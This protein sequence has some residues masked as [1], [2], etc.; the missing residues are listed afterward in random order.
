MAMTA[1]RNSDRTPGFP[2][3]LFGGD[4]KDSQ[5][6]PF[7][8]TRRMHSR[9]GCRPNGLQRNEDDASVD[10]ERSG[11]PASRCACVRG[12][13]EF[14]EATVPRQREAAEFQG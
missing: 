13:H 2:P 12:G 11:G 3:S 14:V 5:S 1:A 10:G 4:E 8:D 9:M 7:R 6:R